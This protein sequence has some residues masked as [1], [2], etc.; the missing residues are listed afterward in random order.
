MKKVNRSKKVYGTKVSTKS[1]CEI[2]LADYLSLVK[3]QPIMNLISDIQTSFAN[4]IAKCEVN[5]SKYGNDLYSCHPI[6]TAYR[7]KIVNLIACCHK[8]IR[9]SRK[10]QNFFHHIDTF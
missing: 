2:L 5:P 8:N 4:F 1:T 7:Q 3:S 6:F 10:V 9:K